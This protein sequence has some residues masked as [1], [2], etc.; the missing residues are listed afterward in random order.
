M[1]KTK[2]TLFVTVLAAALF[3]IGCASV[4]ITKEQLQNGMVAYYPFNGNAMDGSGNG[5]HGKLYGAKLG[6]DRHGAS[7]G[8]YFFDDKSKNQIRMDL[9]GIKFSNAISVSGWIYQDANQTYDVSTTRLLSIGKYKEGVIING[10]PAG[11]RCQI[12][13]SKGD[14]KSR[15]VFSED[16]GAHRGIPPHHIAKEMPEALK[17]NVGQWVSFCMTHSSQ[18]GLKVYVNGKL[19][20]SVP[21]KATEDFPIGGDFSESSIGHGTG[22]SRYFRGALDDIRIYNRALSAKEIKALYDLEKPK[23][24]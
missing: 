18:Q 7:E 10:A 8:A 5:K 15:L 23:G 17:N 19:A 1:M 13:S 11:L 21:L 16:P 24:K 20:G 22:N 6:K 14:V 2:L 9:T 4:K 12:Y 3:G